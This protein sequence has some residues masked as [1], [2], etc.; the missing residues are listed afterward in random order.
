MIY[1]TGGPR[2]IMPQELLWSDAVPW[3]AISAKIYGTSPSR[4]TVEI[5][6]THSYGPIS[7]LVTHAS[8]SGK[9]WALPEGIHR[10][11]QG[12]TEGNVISGFAPGLNIACASDNYRPSSGCGQS[13]DGHNVFAFNIIGRLVV[14]NNAG[15]SASEFNEYD[16]NAIA[17]IADLSTVG[18]TY[19]GEM[20]QGQ[21]E[22]SNTN[23][24][25][26]NCSA[27]MPVIG[28]YASGAQW[29]GTCSGELAMDPVSSAS[30]STWHDAIFGAPW[31][32]YYGTSTRQPFVNC[33]GAP[34]GSFH[35]ESGIVTH[36]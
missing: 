19:I 14:G 11:T 36:C 24:V 15:G 30:A 13:Y 29:S 25:R 4:E 9:M 26:Q 12:F 27:S 3:G 28:A 8:G 32:A 6:P 22:S 31:N 10:P 16:H 34:T 5:S 1:I 18:S 20:L 2:L 17:D 33:T 23:V 7:A 35:V 21:D